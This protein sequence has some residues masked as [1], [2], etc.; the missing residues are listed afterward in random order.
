M[1]SSHGGEILIK[2]G[3]RHYLKR[4]NES[5][6]TTVW[7]CAR[8]KDTKGVREQFLKTE[9]LKCKP[10]RIHAPLITRVKRGEKSSGTEN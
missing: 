5:S 3:Y 6:R 8:S 9:I 7:N 4:T 10:N 1:Q 2:G